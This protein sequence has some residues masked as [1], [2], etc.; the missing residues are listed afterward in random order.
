MSSSN[1][2]SPLSDDFAWNPSIPDEEDEQEMTWDDILVQDEKFADMV[3][4]LDSMNRRGKEALEKTTKSEE[5]SLG[6]PK[7][8]NH[9]DIPGSSNSVA[10]GL[11]KN[12][13][14]ST[15]GSGSDKTSLKGSSSARSQAGESTIEPDTTTSDTETEAETTDQSNVQ[16]TSRTSSNQLE[17]SDGDASLTSSSFDI[18]RGMAS[19]SEF[20]ISID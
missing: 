3:R 19:N 2:L 9:F 7:V 20:S 12:S 8:L 6:G 4:L 1:L 14:K 13:L 11:S 17:S 15:I 18:S 16:D 5:K 10:L